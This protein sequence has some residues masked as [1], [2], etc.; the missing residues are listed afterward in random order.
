TGWI[1]NNWP[2][3]KQGFESQV[4][5]THSDPQKTGGLYNIVKV[6]PS[7]AKD[8]QWWTQYIKVDGKHIIVKIDGKT[9]V[10]YTEPANVQGPNKIGSGMFCLQ[11]HDPKS[12]VYYRDIRVKRLP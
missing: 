12:T 7:P 4:A 11:G 6:N 10:D 2:T 3:L 9:V 5:N 8:N 1:T